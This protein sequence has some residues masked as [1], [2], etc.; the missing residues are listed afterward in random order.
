MQTNKVGVVGAGAMG[1]G[2][3]QIASQAGHQVILYDLSLTT[4]DESASKLAKVMARLVEKKRI[5]L[6]E[7]IEIQGRIVRSTQIDLFADCDLVVEAVVEN[8]AVKHSVFKQIENIVSS[9]CIVASNTSSL[10]ITSLAAGCNHPERVLGLHFFNPAPLMPLVEIVPAIQTS[11][12]L[13]LHLI[14]LMKDWG[15][16]PVIAKDTPG[17]IVNR[18]A[19]PFYGEALRILDEGIADVPTIDTVMSNL[20]F[21]MGPFQL[22]DLIGHDVNYA[23]TES[24]FK[25][26]YCD[27]RFMPSITQLKL[28]EAGW[29]GRKAGRGFYNYPDNSTDRATNVEIDSDTEVLIAERIIAM[30]INEAADAVYYGIASPE[31]VDIAMQKGVNYP[32]GLLVWADE[33]GAEKV[34][35]IIDSLKDEYGETR[36]RCSTLLRK[37][38]REGG[39]F[40]S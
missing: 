35:K 34:V 28:V 31:D 5:T 37:Q 32:K 9:E 24:V 30:L 20:G 39:R 25:S 8:L 11:V 22:M 26:F 6:E 3:A 36:Y 15:K 21:K 23:V 40:Y 14:S 1:A 13:P 19:R 33:W 12:E 17:F 38:A 16:S 18:V 27:P 2:I 7:S 29:L 10:S 4:L